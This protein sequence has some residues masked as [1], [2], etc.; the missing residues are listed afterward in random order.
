P[1]PPIPTLFPYTT[2]FRSPLKQQLME[3]GVSPERILVNPNAVDPEWFHPDSGGANVR[4][5]L[6]FRPGHIVVCFV[7][8]FSYWHGVGVL[9][10]SEEHTSELQSR[11]HLVC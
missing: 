5:E 10:R 2:L 4:L 9:E 6:G 8:T 1:P 3:A 11:G 7:G